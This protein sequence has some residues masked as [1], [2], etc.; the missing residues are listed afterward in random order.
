[1]NFPSKRKKAIAFLNLVVAISVLVAVTLVTNTEFI[2]PPF[3]ATA[4]T[5]YPDP[6]WRMYRSTAILLSYL[7]CG[8]IAVVFSAFGLHGI[9][10]ATVASF[11][12]FGV[13]VGLN[14]EHPPAILAAFLGVL[15]RVGPLYIVH[16]VVTGVIT[17][18]GVNYLLTKY[19]EPKI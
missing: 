5:K 12:A 11:V 1:M 9:L 19:V 6:D 7:L 2:L 14:V 4:A 10:M 17:I 16:P 18:E 15:E 8:A 13:S 3:L